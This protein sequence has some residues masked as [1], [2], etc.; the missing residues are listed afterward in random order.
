MKRHVFLCCLLFLALFNLSLAWD[1]WDPDWEQV[2]KAIDESC[3]HRCEIIFKTRRICSNFC[4]FTEHI[5]EDHHRIFELY[6]ES[7]S[8]RNALEWAMNDVIDWKR[9]TNEEDQHLVA[10]RYTEEFL[11]WAH[12]SNKKKQ[13]LEEL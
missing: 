6:K 12:A 11:K 8:P 10:E 9:K 5:K 3:I 7:G 2:T 13:K 1:E 4:S